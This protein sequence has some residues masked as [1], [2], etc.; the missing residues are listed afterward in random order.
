MAAVR[1]SQR[2]RSDQRNQEVQQG[3]GVGPVS[4]IGGDRNG[5]EDGRK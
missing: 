3:H 2:Y 5:H 4:V 1:R